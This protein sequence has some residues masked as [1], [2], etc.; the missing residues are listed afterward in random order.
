MIV[1]AVFG[2]PLP[3]PDSIGGTPGRHRHEALLARHLPRGRGAPMAARLEVDGSRPLSNA[4]PSRESLL[5]PKRP[6]RELTHSSSSRRATAYVIVTSVQA[7]A[8]SRDAAAKKPR[9]SPTSSFDGAFDDP[10]SSS[11]MSRY[12]L[13][14]RLILGFF[15]AARK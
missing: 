12:R 4:R 11:S 10:S 9:T 14:R 3:Q 8:S 5:S 6:C 1:V 13:G 2:T 15:I 7:S